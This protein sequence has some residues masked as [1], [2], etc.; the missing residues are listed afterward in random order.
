MFVSIEVRTP[1]QISEYVR[2]ERSAGRQATLTREEKRSVAGETNGIGRDDI[3]F[4]QRTL[5][6]HA[7][8]SPVS[9]AEVREARAFLREMG[10]E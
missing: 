5:I 2:A 10:I 9:K 3:G 8:G 4:A 1:N 6:R 7:L